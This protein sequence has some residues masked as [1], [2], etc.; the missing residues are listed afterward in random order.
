MK[1][2]MC[3]HGVEGRAMGCYFYGKGMKLQFAIDVEFLTIVSV[4][5]KS[6]S[7]VHL[8]IRS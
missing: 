4:V 6:D 7:E 8:Q 3:C 2:F 1:I 5:L